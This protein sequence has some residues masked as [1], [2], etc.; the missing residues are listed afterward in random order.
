MGCTT[1]TAVEGAQKAVF[2]NEDGVTFPE[3]RFNGRSHS[4]HSMD[5]LTN[6]YAAAHARAPT[7]G[8]HSNW[9]K[10]LEKVLEEIKDH[11]KALQT[12]VGYKRSVMDRQRDFIE[13]N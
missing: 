9:V 2:Q 13:S 8:T 4:F 5:D 3:V 10:Q 6:P 12:V 11:P 1:S 7:E